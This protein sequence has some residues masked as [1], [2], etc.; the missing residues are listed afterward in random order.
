MLTP[1]TAFRALCLGITVVADIILWMR[2]LRA[3]PDQVQRH[4]VAALIVLGLLVV[5]FVIPGW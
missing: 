4:R 5:A 1:I 3:S 2:V